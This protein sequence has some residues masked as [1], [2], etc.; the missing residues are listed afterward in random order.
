VSRFSFALRLPG[1]ERIRYHHSVMLPA[2]EIAV[3]NNGVPLDLFRC[4][5]KIGWLLAAKVFDRHVL[6]LPEVIPSLPPCGISHA[7]Y[8]ESVDQHLV[9]QMVDKKPVRVTERVFW[10]FA[11]SGGLTREIKFACHQIDD[12]GEVA[13]RAITACLGLRRLYQTVDALEDAVVDA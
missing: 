4:R 9:T 11:V 1:V 7:P 10:L 12:A 2:A 13:E 8:D 6:I 5:L 3:H